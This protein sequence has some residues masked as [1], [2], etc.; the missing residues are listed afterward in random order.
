MDNNLNE[1]INIEL[2]K[3][4]SKVDLKANNSQ[5]KKKVNRLINFIVR[6]IGKQNK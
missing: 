4:L 1:S 6:R 2:K 3:K 5:M